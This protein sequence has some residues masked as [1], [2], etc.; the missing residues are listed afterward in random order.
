V[1]A[2]LAAASKTVREAQ[3]TWLQI[4]LSSASFAPR[5]LYGGKLALAKEGLSFSLSRYSAVPGVQVTGKVE[6]VP[7]G[8]PLL[9]KGTVRVSGAAAVAG[10]LTFS[11]NSISGRLG[12]RSVK[13]SY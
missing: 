7:G 13:G 11:K 12:G 6:F 2:T 8:L 4:V 10:T 9:Y 3:A 1:K 5:G